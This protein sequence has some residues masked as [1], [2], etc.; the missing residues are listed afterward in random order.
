ML[1]IGID[2]CDRMLVSYFFYFSV[3]KL[4]NEVERIIVVVNGVILNKIIYKIGIV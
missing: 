4:V 1:I 2:S 3:S